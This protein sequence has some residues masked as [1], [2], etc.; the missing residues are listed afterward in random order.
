MGRPRQYG[1]D[2]ERQRAHRQRVEATTA[3]VD[4]EALERLHQRLDRLHSAVVA[5]AKGGD[6]AA[7]AGQAGS[8]ETMLEKLTLHFE[9]CCQ[10]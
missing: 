2:A 8:I 7:R 3:R 4:R 5:A 9:H 10:E 1:S 6:P